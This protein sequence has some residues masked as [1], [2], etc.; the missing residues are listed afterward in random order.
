MSPSP[1]T[2]PVCIQWHFF[3]FSPSYFIAKFMKWKFI[4]IFQDFTV[5]FPF[6]NS[7]FHSILNRRVKGGG[8]CFTT[9]HFGHISSPTR[10][11]RSNPCTILINFCARIKT[12]FFCIILEITTGFRGFFEV[13]WELKVE[14][15]K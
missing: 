5:E 12:E 4:K 6:S 9:T 7:P 2:V 8:V 10:I 15:W 1:Y 13:S 3:T 11:S 14:S